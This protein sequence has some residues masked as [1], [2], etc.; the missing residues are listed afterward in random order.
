[1]WLF[2]LSLH[3]CCCCFVFV[4][5]QNEAAVAAIFS[6]LGIEEEEEETSRGGVPLPSRGYRPTRPPRPPA[7]HLAQQNQREGTHHR[8]IGGP[9]H[10]DHLHLCFDSFTATPNKA[11]LQSHAHGILQ[12]FAQTCDCT[13]G[14]VT[15]LSSGGLSPRFM[16]CKCRCR[17]LNSVQ[18]IVFYIYYISIIY[19]NKISAPI[20]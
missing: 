13:L 1:M 19:M 18:T 16:H 14:S 3:R 10:L 8:S 2:P 4:C 5:W 6:Y 15:F 20:K 17:L 12:F 11:N 7:G 9:N